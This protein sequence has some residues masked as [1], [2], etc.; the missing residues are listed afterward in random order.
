MLAHY[1]T[2]DERAVPWLEASLAHYRT[3]ADGWGLAFTLAILGVVAEDAGDYD[4]AAARFAEGLVHARAADLPVETGILLFHLGIVA[5]GQGDRERAGEW[6]NE[7]LAVQ[8][9]SGDLGYGAAE[10][11]AFLG[12][13]ACEQGDFRRSVE[14]QR[15][16]LSLHLEIGS[17]E[18]LAVS[19]AN[20]AML[21]VATQRPAVAARL[22]GAAVAQREAIGN[23]FKLPE[24]AVYDRALDAARSVLRDDDFAAAW[25]SGRA[26]SLA[27]A[28][29]A[30][31]AALDEI[32]GQATSGALASRPAS[33]APGAL[34]GLTDRELEVLH[35]LVEGR[36][37]REIAEALFIS[38]RTAQG[39]VARIFTKLNV[40]TRTAAAAAAL[41]AGLLP[42]TPPGS[43]L[44]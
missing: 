36:S 8:R 17:Q 19:L 6:V 24:R 11:L 5:W 12:V 35:L 40:N 14:L 34:A 28:I 3:I 9:A 16:S 1:A 38:P 25:N 37:D 26:L 42:D 2:D 13:F 22:F 27:E 10:S 44:I 21:A 32:G 41:Q 31:F 18:V 33:T 4:R 43:S 7:A 30:A 23:P 39:H 20:V 15:E 29:A